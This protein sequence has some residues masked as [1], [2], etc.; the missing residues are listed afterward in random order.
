MM[1]LRI[2]T[3]ETAPPEYGSPVERPPDWAG[4]TPAERAAWMID[5]KRRL[6]E[7][8]ESWATS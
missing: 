6:R 8:R 1:D 7:E 5:R 3:T 4:K 2:L